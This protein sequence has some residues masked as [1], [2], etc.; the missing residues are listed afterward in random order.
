MGRGRPRA[1]GAGRAPR[2][3][4]IAAAGARPREDAG[5]RVGRADHRRRTWPGKAKSS[6]NRPRPVRRRGSSLRTT[7]LPMKRKPLEGPDLVL[8]SVIQMLLSSEF[9]PEGKHMAE[10][11]VCRHGEIAEERPAGSCARAGWRSG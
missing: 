10:M 8:V 9:Q 1:V 6:L 2:T 7:G 11:L 3:P 5:V 4:G